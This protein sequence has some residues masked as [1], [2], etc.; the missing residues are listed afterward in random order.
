MEVEHGE[1]DVPL[2]TGVSTSMIV[3][4]RVNQ[5]EK[6]MALSLSLSLSLP[7][8]CSFFFHLRWI[9]IYIYNVINDHDD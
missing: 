9:Y 3:E 1:V 4:G 2:L 8:A 7:A 6:S 5:V